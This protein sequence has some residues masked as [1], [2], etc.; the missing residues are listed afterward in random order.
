MR[1]LILSAF[2]DEYASDTAEQ[3]QALREFGIEYTEVR[4][5]DG[6]NISVLSEN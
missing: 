1:N 6:K 2:S 3:A 5:L 4:H